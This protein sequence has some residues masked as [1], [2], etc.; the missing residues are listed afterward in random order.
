MTGLLPANLPPPPL[1]YNS[2]QATVELP[3][4]KEEVR[5]APIAK[6]PKSLLQVQQSAYGI[7]PA[8]RALENSDSYQ[9]PWFKP[10]QPPLQSFSLPPA[11]PKN[12]AACGVPKST[13]G[14]NPQQLPGGS[15]MQPQPLPPIRTSH[16]PESSYYGPRPTISN[17]SHRDPS[18]FAR[19]K[20]SLEN[21]LPPGA[22]ELF[23]YQVLVDHLQL[24][25]ARW[26]A[27]AYLNSPTPFSDTMAA[28]ND[29]FDCIEAYCCC[30]GL[31][32]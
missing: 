7:V 27:D 2:V 31:T 13:P 1:P 14:C 6:P 9:R 29:K 22:T 20:L 16:I 28:L 24:E 23:K 5:S 18:G 11:E 25:E 12:S 21:L 26:I 19:L 30:V 3:Y 32:R 10:V 17:F 8:T 15:W 4:V